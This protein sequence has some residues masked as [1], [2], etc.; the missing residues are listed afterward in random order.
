MPSKILVCLHKKGSLLQNGIL[1]I[2]TNL[3]TIQIG[4][5]LQY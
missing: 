4:F 1:L 3:G 5:K 2:L